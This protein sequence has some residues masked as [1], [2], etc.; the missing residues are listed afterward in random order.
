MMLGLLGLTA[1]FMGAYVVGVRAAGRPARWELPGVLAPDSCFT[2]E[3]L[4]DL[5]KPVFW[6]RQLF[7]PE[8]DF[9]PERLDAL[10]HP[11]YWSRDICAPESCFSPERLRDLKEPVHW[12]RTIGV[13]APETAFTP[14]RFMELTDSD[15]DGPA[16]WDGMGPGPD[17]YCPE[18]RDLYWEAMQN[19]EA[20]VREAR[21]L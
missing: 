15:P 6:N 18:G 11:V 19:I 9:T 14:K 7:A 10:L 13:F 8:S 2:P 5:C 1:L 20:S 16:H 4:R 12:Y 17:V 3:R 21:T